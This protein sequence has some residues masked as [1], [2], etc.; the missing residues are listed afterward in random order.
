[1]DINSQLLVILSG[2][3]GKG[4]GISAKALSDR[5]GFIDKSYRNV[6]MIISMLRDEGHAICGMPKDG[7]Y[8]AATPD[9]LKETCTFLR[10]RAMHSLRLEAKLMKIPLPDLLGQLHLPT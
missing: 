10:N 1:M 4:N 5:M 8:I 9:E 7:Y 3:I 2:H 6:R